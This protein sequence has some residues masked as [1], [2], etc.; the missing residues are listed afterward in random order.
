MKNHLLLTGLFFIGIIAC[1][2]PKEKALQ[3]IDTLEAQDTSFTIENSAKLKDAYIDFADKY[4]DDEKAPEFLFKAGQRMSVLASEKNDMAIHQ[5]SIAIFE[6]ICNTYPKN[7]YAEEAFFL[8]AYVYEN[9][10]KDIEKAKV[11][12][13]RFIER[14]PQS[15]LKE[16]AE[17]AIKNIGI[18]PAEII[19]RA[20]E[21]QS[22]P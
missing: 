18:D 4:P 16:D 22:N 1:Q 12:Y 6:R 13:E 7:H 19:R 20:Q 21:K 9:S 8:S 5:E 2:S 11:R 10:L 15:E 14:Y 3:V 17:L